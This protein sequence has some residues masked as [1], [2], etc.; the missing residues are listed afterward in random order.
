M[1]FR[2]DGMFQGH[3][4]KEQ[5]HRHLNRNGPGFLTASFECLPNG[6]VDMPQAHDSITSL[7]RNTRKTDS[8]AVLAFSQRPNLRDLPQAAAPCRNEPHAIWIP[9]GRSA[10]ASGR[11]QQPR[12]GGVG[13]HGPAE[14]S[15]I[16][17]VIERSDSG[18]ND[19]WCS[20]TRPEAPK[21][22]GSVPPT[23]QGMSPVVRRRHG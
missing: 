6:V 2:H 3:G 10:C 17:T 22:S 13:S 5:G 8:M 14:P 21:G 12:Q 16:R 9:I 4:V 1:N 11:I 20:P 19:Q 23:L 18:A 7:E 15:P